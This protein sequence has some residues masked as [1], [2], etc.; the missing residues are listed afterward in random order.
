[1]FI[2]PLLGLQI[3]VCDSI[4]ADE[5][6][7]DIALLIFSISDLFDANAITDGPAPLIV[8][9]IAPALRA[10]FLWRH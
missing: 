8:T 4:F 6:P 10:F 9:P 7:L 1:M 3:T 5:N 2:A